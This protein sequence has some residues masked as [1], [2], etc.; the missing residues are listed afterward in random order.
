MN[1][2]NIYL[3]NRVVFGTVSKLNLKDYIEKSKYY[4]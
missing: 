3:N 4:E 1:L 2:N